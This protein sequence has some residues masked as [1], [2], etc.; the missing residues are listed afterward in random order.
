MS[1]SAGGGARSPTRRAV[2][3]LRGDADLRAIQEFT[4]LVAASA[5]SS[6]QRERL[7]RAVG[8]P[9]TTASMTA[10]RL[11]ERAG[12]LAMSELARRLGLDQSTLSRQVRPLE[13]E[14]LV[15]RS[16]DRGDRRVVWLRVSAKGIRLLQRLRDVELNDFDVALSDWSERDRARLA[17]LLDRFRTDLLRVRVDPLGWSVGKRPESPAGELEVGT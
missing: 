8:A 7:R 17:T 6:A 15:L 5:R 4:D 9:V 14:A 1:R 2:R 11:I 13:D 12:P 16:N 10:L 3:A